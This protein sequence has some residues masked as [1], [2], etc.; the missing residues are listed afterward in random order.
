MTKSTSSTRFA[1][2]VGINLYPSNGSRDASLRGRNLQGCVNDVDGVRKLLEDRFQLLTPSVLAS[3]PLANSVPE[4]P[5]DCL[6][7]LANIRREIFNI[8]NEAHA[9]DQFFFYFSGHGARL[10]RTSNSPGGR[11]TDPS[12]LTADYFCGE[13]ALRGWVL[14]EWLREFNEKGIHVVIVL[15]S[16]HAGGA[17]RSDE[18]VITSCRTP[19]P[20]DFPPNLPADEASIQ[21]KCTESD[22]RDGSLEDS[23]DINPRYFTLMAACRP[24]QSALE[25]DLD[26]NGK[27]NGVFTYALMKS[28]RSTDRAIMSY[29]S[30]RDSIASIVKHHSGQDPQVFGQDRL[31]FFGK[32]ETSITPILA[33]VRRDTI[34]LP[35]GQIHGIERCAEFRGRPPQSHLLLS[36]SKVD[37]YTSE[38]NKPDGL[39]G[40][41]PPRLEVLPYRWVSKTPFKMQIGPGFEPGF[42]EKLRSS[43]QSRIIGTIEVAELSEDDRI[44]GFTEW[45]LRKR[46]H[47]DVDVSGASSLVGYDG[48]VRGLRIQGEQH[49][50]KSA[51]ALAHLFRFGQILDL[52][53][54]APEVTPFKVTLNSGKLGTVGRIFADGTKYT[55]KFENTTREELYFAV[56]IFGPGFS[57]KQL[58]PPQDASLGVPARGSRSFQFILSIPGELKRNGGDGQNR[59]T[60]RDIIRTVVTTDRGI[61]LKSLELPH[62]W[63]AGQAEHERIMDSGRIARVVHSS[64]WWIH[65]DFIRSEH[66]T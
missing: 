55:Y 52:R 36:I 12:L 39:A 59:N 4:D 26:G 23:W 61:S 49:A 17:W 32:E 62:I 54:G 11:S 13:P 60:H 43:L 9:G 35:V 42:H 25:K 40:T 31:M 38:A 3:P 41:L 44:S 10:K 15:D 34:T 47:A 30:T 64:R 37:D 28:L 58:F 63:D 57:I 46:G 51:R 16:C 20:W 50:A 56:M 33:E 48:P 6:P 24:G 8:L 29:R 14:N 2:L 45:S 18:A 19:V 65:D 7:T 21:E 66:T 27:R 1:L 53:V 22:V 5:E